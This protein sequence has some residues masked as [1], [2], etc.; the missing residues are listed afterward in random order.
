MDRTRD[1]GQFYARGGGGGGGGGKTPMLFSVL[2]CAG[3]GVYRTLVMLLLT[4]NSVFTVVFNLELLIPRP[5]MYFTSVTEQDQDKAEAGLQQLLSWVLAVALRAPGAPIMLVGTHKDKR[6]NTSEHR[7]LNARMQEL[8]APYMSREDVRILPCESSGLLFHAVDN[9]IGDKDPV[10]RELRARIEGAA[11]HDPIGYLQEE[12][13]AR[14]IQVYEELK[15]QVAAAAKTEEEAASQRSGAAED[16]GQDG[17]RS[18]FPAVVPVTEIKKLAERYG[19]TDA[20][21]V[22]LLLRR[23]HELGAILYFP[24]AGLG[25]RVV[26]N[27]S[28]L[29]EL[30]SRIIREPK[31]HPPPA[32]EL[33]M[34]KPLLD[35]D[36]KALCFYDRAR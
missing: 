32:S 26:V 19:V 20:R 13:P 8:L 5:W 36:E 28:A 10:V 25:D 3:Q 24:G 30:A 14:W 21:E 33:P 6:S 31:N 35:L 1:L 23:L 7:D 15:R 22:E 17:G 34:D 12:V 18:A 9:T 27:P 4:R 29:V 11:L 2:N 16:T